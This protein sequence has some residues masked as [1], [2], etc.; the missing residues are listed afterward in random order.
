MAGLTA[1]G[2]R[3]RSPAAI[4]A[5]T[6]STSLNG[7]NT[8]STGG[9][10]R[11]M[12]SVQGGSQHD[13]TTGNGDDT[14]CV[15]GRHEPSVARQRHRHRLCLRLGL[16]RSRPALARIQ[17]FRHR[18][19][20]AVTVIGG[21]G[22]SNWLSRMASCRRARK[23]A[24]IQAGLNAG[25][26]SDSIMGGAGADQIIIGRTARTRSRR[27]TATTYVDVINGTNTITAG[28]GNDTLSRSKGGTNLVTLGSGSDYGQGDSPARLDD[29]CGCGCGHDRRRFSSPL[30]VNARHWEPARSS[31]TGTLHASAQGSVIHAGLTAGATDSIIWRRM[32]PTRSSSRTARTRST[33]GQWR[34]LRRHPEWHEHDHDRHG[35]GATIE[36]DRAARTTSHSRAATTACIMASGNDTIVRRPARTSSTQVNA[37]RQHSLAAASRPISRSAPSGNDTV[38]GYGRRP[39]SRSRVTV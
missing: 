30:T 12:S 27:A 9:G 37:N 38:I 33:T 34:R 24:I 4:R 36:L 11:Y 10:K 6:R 20:I 19:S 2:S 22:T 32:A 14:G 25:S 16:R 21:S 13:R 7:T 26:R 1:G 5:P 35:G 23:A 29:Q 18:R 8:I 17:D 3:I 28:N 31:A 39:R 15:Y